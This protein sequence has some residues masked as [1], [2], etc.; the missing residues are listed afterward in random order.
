MFYLG[1]LT[2]GYNGSDLRNFVSE[3]AMQPVEEVQTARRFNKVKMG[4]KTIY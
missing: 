4:K 2:K 1:E 3:A